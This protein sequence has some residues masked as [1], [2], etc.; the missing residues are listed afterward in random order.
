VDVLLISGRDGGGAHAELVRSLARDHRVRWLRG[1]GGA[2]VPLEGVDVQRVPGRAPPFR[3]V[4]GQLVHP[5]LERALARA[6]RERF[7]GVVHVLG[8]GGAEASA[9]PWVARRLGAPTLVDVVAARALCHR[10]TLV[11]ERA[12]ACGAWEDPA[13]CEACCLTPGSGALRPAAARLGRWLRAF[14]GLSPFPERVKFANR[15]EMVFNGL[16]A[17]DVVICPTEA[18]AALLER[19]GVARRVLR[20]LPAE[21]RS[22]QA[23][24]ALYREAAA[25]VPQELPAPP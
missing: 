20:V 13:R 3:R 7:P 5:A 10:G 16:L 2:D 22:A 1:D 4:L 23:L 6:I 9:T 18:D 24:E 12:A 19:A 17:A 21:R 14:G 15:L 11:D 25:V 8:F